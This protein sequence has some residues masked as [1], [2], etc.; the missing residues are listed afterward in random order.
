MIRVKIK[1]TLMYTLVN[2]RMIIMFV[3]KHHGNISIQVYS[4][5]LHLTCGK[6]GGGGGG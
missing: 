4:P 3:P 1:K 6:N 2:Y 5:S